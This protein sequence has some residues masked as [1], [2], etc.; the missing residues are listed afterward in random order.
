MD[1]KKTIVL[2]GNIKVMVSEDL[3][4]KLLIRLIQFDAKIDFDLMVFKVVDSYYPLKSKEYYSF[5]RCCSLR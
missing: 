1:Y 2:F 4:Y 5:F 3:F